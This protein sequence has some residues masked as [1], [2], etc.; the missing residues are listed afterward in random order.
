M[1]RSVLRQA[2]ALVLKVMRTRHYL[3][4]GMPVSELG[5]GAWQ[6]GVDSGWKAVSD[7]EADR[8]IRTAL[9]HGI[10]FFDTAPNY[11]MGT[12]EA[13]LGKVFKT[14]DR[15]K[16]VINS[17]FGRLDNGEVD[18]S[19]KHIRGS[20]ERSLMRLN[21][22]FLD[23][24]IIHSPPTEFL[25]GNKNDHYAILERLEEEGKIMAYG[26][27][28]DFEEEINLLMETTNAKV[29]QSFFNIFHQDCKRSFQLIK[30]KGATVIA[31]IPFD[32]GW[33]TGKYG[34]DSQFTGVRDRW[35][36]EDIQTR[37]RLLER[38]KDLVSGHPSL[39]SAA[40][41]FCTSFDAVSTVI[42]GAVSQEQLL[43]NIDAMNHP[44]DPEAVVQ[45]EA[46]YEEEVRALKLPW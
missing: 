2:K 23:S 12:S 25:D 43:A 42:P 34:G 45:L 15:S 24:V 14:L 41:T 7:A 3:E 27:S 37:A 21:V 6:L 13:R 22:D 36:R 10:N 30:S 5:F 1:E 26:A 40:L 39:I 35:S 16:V 46:F 17:K 28:V 33:L 32:S 31:K 9:D 29:I 38:V 44:L 4:D 18:F 20:V 11:G 19:A 8:M